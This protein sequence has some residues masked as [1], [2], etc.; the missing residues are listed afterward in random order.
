MRYSPYLLA[1]MAEHVVQQESK[2]DSRVAV[3]YMLIG[4]RTGL[5]QLDVRR[6]IYALAGVEV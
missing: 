3:L 2:N 4:Q 5:D 6:R 1:Q